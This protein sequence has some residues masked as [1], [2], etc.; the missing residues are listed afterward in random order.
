MDSAAAAA[1]AGVHQFEPI[2]YLVL[3]GFLLLFVLLS[4]YYCVKNA[5]TL[6]EWPWLA[7]LLD[8]LDDERPAR[9]R[10]QAISLDGKH[11]KLT[12]FLTGASKHD[13]LPATLSLFASY[14][15]PMTLIGR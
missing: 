3:G 1:S 2:D 5:F 7:R 11:A 8:W 12:E 14:I 9:S 4:S 6:D 10:Q 15:S 13:V